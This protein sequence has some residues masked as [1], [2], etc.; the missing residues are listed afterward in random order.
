[1]KIA[2]LFLLALLMN[3][4]HNFVVHNSEKLYEQLFVEIN[5]K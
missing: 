1:M 2:V 3:Y 4:E 5:T